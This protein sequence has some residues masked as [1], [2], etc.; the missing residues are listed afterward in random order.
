[1]RVLL[2]DPPSFSRGSI[3]IGLAYLSSML[4]SKEHQVKVIDLNRRRDNMEKRLTYALQ[5]VPDIIGCSVTSATLEKGIKT[6]KFCKERHLGAFY[7]IGGVG[8]VMNPEK[9]L[10]SYRDILDCVVVREAEVTLIELLEKLNGGGKLSDVEGIVYKENG[11]IVRNRERPFIKNLDDFPFPDYKVFDSFDGH[12]DY[13]PIM[14]SRGCP[15]SCVFCLNSVISKRKW[16]FRSPQNVVDEIK[17]AIKEYKFDLIEIW[18]ENFSLDVNRAIKICDLIIE[19]KLNIKYKLPNGIRADRVTPELARKLKESGCVSVNIGV[20]NADPETFSYVEKGESLEDI[21][22]AITVLKSEG[23][24]VRASMVIGLPHTTYESTLKSMEFIKEVNINASWYL[25]TPFEGT[26]LHRYVTENKNARFLEDPNSEKALTFQRVTFETD[27]F[28]KDERLKAYY[29]ANMDYSGERSRYFSYKPLFMFSDKWYLNFVKSFLIVLKYHPKGLIDLTLEWLNIYRNSANRRI[30]KY[31]K[32]IVT[33]LQ[34]F[35]KAQKRHSISMDQK[36]KM[37]QELIGVEYWDK[38]WS[39]I[40]LPS[41]INKQEY[42]FY[43]F[44]KLFKAYLNLKDDKTQVKF[45]EIGCAPGRWLKY[46][47]VEFKF[48]TCGVDYSKEGCKITKQNLKL[49]NIKS[50]VIYGDIFKLKNE[51]KFDVVFSS[52]VIE[53]F[54]EPFKV[55]NKHYDFLKAGGTLI[56]VVPNMNGLIGFLHK[57]SN[58]KLYDKHVRI[59]RENLKEYAI[60]LKTEIIKCDYFGSWNLGILNFEEGRFDFYKLRVLIDRVIKGILRKLRWEP[61]S[62]IFSPYIVLICKKLT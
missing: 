23:L 24:L 59:T 43:R 47:N 2:I 13:Y 31:I 50:E 54:K 51:Q 46:F 40:D 37:N 61:E 56:I 33:L 18:D 22:N 48:D 27:E 41:D 21:K 42:I 16:R 53:H 25:A 55:I 36:S 19:E 14:T 17:H 29:I 57:I 15:F 58:K 7:I 34:N 3:N 12:L 1:M 60:R 32:K 62:R 49:S 30:K 9:I 38:S 26:K 35:L 6:L 11:K 8:V 39:C 20:E 45:L 5:W 4:Q 44:N 28:P 52:G 10:E